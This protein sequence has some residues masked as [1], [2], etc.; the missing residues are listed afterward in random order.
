[1]CS[2]PK[3]PERAENAFPLFY[4]PLAL[5]EDHASPSDPTRNAP[6]HRTNRPR[7]PSSHPVR[8]S[9]IEQ[10]VQDL[11]LLRTRVPPSQHG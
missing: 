3:E 2:S 10:V 8:K 1:M 11:D 4:D 9:R 6:Q 7:R 5:A